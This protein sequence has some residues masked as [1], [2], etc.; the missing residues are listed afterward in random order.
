MY[1]ESVKHYIIVHQKDGIKLNAKYKISDIEIELQDK[2]F[3]RIH[4]SFIINLKKQ[5][6]LLLMMSKLER[7]KYQ[8]EQVIRNMFLK[9]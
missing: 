3:L 6:L 5:L 9:Y 8:L 4:R 2:N 1:I 7:L